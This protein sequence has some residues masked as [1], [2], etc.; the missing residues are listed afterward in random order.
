M[1][2]DES[3]GITGVIIDFNDGSSVITDSNG[4][5]RKNGLTGTVTVTP[6]CGYKNGEY[7][8]YNANGSIDREIE[9]VPF[10]V[11]VDNYSVEV[12]CSDVSPYQTSYNTHGIVF[13]YERAT[14]AYY[15]F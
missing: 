15:Y 12:D 4:N 1:N 5:W 14:S 13:G 8:I 2:T 3:A 9:L 11:P 10:F 6:L 7:E